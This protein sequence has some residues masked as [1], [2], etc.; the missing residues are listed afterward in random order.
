MLRA[1]SLAIRKASVLVRA[2]AADTRT[3]ASTREQH[4]APD[5]ERQ[6]CRHGRSGALS[7][8]HARALRHLHSAAALNRDHAAEGLQEHVSTVPRWGC[9]QESKLC[10][11]SITSA[12]AHGTTQGEVVFP[13]MATK[14]W[15]QCRGKVFCSGIFSVPCA[16][17]SIAAG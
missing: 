9:S 4:H 13:P 6:H 8:F 16:L 3:G 1:R 7:T 15:W 5:S 10:S 12:I 17:H 14:L 2:F 11:Q